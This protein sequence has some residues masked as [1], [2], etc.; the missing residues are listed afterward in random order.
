MSN[1]T[2]EQIERALELLNKWPRTPRAMSKITAKT[3]VSL[4]TLTEI[5]CKYNGAFNYT[6]EGKGQPHLQKYIVAI[7]NVTVSWDNN[8]PDIKKAR[9]N[10]ENGTH[11]MCTGR[12]GM[13]LILY[14]IPRKQ[15]TYRKPYFSA[16]E[17]E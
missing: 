1:Y 9:E 10:Y 17:E 6:E 4:Y 13:N 16:M 3:G 7:T 14:S 8:N 15:K 2:E 5:D 11:E 12:D